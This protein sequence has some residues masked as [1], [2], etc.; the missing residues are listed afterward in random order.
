M[1]VCVYTGG[2]RLKGQVM[3][4]KINVSPISRLV[5]WP[6][7]HTHT[8]MSHKTHTCLPDSFFSQERVHMGTRAGWEGILVNVGAPH[9]DVTSVSFPLLSSQKRV[10]FGCRSEP[11]FCNKVALYRLTLSCLSVNFTSL[12]RK[13]HP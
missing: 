2:S 10:V 3:T 9:Q 8:L 11:C 5:H 13:M 6:Y 12:K 1:C 7:I 4:N